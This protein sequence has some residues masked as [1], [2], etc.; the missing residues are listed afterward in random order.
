MMTVILDLR[1]ATLGL[2]L[3]LF[4]ILY[5]VRRFLFIREHRRRNAEADKDKDRTTA[6][7]SKG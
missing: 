2:G 7:S 6:P 4:T 3:V 5:V 1:L